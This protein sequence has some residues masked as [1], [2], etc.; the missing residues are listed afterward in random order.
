MVPIVLLRGLLRESGHWQSMIDALTQTSP[1]LVLITPNVPGNG[2]KYR[3]LSPLNIEQMLPSMLEQ[4]PKNCHR[5]HLVAISMGSM[6]ASHW[7]HTLP[8][9]VASL[10]LINPSFSRYSPF[11]HRINIY[12]LLSIGVSRLRGNDAFQESIIRWTSPTSL[13]QPEVLE[14]HINL[15]RQ[16]PVSVCNAIRQLCAAAQFKGQRSPPACPSQIIVSTADKLVDSRCGE[17]IAKAW[18]I[19]IVR[20]DCDAHDLPLEK[21]HALAHHLLHWL[22]KVELVTNSS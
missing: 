8:D 5:Y 22:A 16:H 14:H 17:A 11:W 2:E 9:Q 13:H 18:Q 6:L 1:E 7:A 4:L 10:T 12:A 19:E 3:E 20:F 21:P 15:A